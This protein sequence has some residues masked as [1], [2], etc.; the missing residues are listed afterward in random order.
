MGNGNSHVGLVDTENASHS[1]TGTIQEVYTLLSIWIAHRE[2]R[3]E[4]D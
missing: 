3:L 4:V 2:T 1:T